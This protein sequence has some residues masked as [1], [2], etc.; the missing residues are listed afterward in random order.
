MI[1]LKLSESLRFYLSDPVQN[2]IL[3]KNSIEATEIQQFSTLMSKVKPLH[4]VQ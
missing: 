1:N 2:K 3:S 4:T